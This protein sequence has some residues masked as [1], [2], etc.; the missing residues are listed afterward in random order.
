MNIFMGLI[1][2][3]MD[4]VI[5]LPVFNTAV[6]HGPSTCMG[7]SRVMLHIIACFNIKQL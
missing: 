6:I 5:C 4:N 1:L 7:P 3:V 2:H